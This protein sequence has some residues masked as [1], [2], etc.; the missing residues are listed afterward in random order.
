[1]ANIEFI[2]NVI[3]WG[4]AVCLLLAYVLISSGRTHGKSYLYQGINMLGSAG[5]IVN[6]YYF[7]AIPSV[8]LNF[9]WLL[10]GTTTILKFSKTRSLEK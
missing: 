3:G 8:A 7:G 2:V 9:T 1:M 10:I 6:S 4:G 5:F